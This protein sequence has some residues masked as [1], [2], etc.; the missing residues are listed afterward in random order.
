LR[1]GVSS[2]RKVIARIARGGAPAKKKKLSL[3]KGAG[4]GTL[5][6]REKIEVTYSK[7]R[8]RSGLQ[9][10]RTKKEENFYETSSC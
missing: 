1:Q 2:A 8:K 3:R 7:G 9:N 5:L 10:L 6:E 4:A